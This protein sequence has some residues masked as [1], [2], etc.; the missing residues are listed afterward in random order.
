MTTTL[1][2]YI[3]KIADDALIMGQRLSE[4][5]GHGPYLEEDLA[6]TN[7]ALDQLGQANYLFQYAAKLDGKNK[8][9]DDVAFLR[10][11][12]QYLN[13]QLVELPNG[14]YAQ[15][16]VKIFLFAL[17]QQLLYTHL[18]QSKDPQ[19]AAVATKS[20]KEVNYHLQHA[21]TWITCF[22][23][24]TTESR[25]RLLKALRFVWSYTDDL[26]APID[27]EATLVQEGIA[28][29]S[30]VLRQEWNK[31]IMDAF[32]N[33]NIPM[34]TIAYMHKNSRK[35]THTEHMGFILADM[36]YMQRAYP[37]CKW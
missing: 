32:A 17:Y 4:W 12:K 31:K 6:I 29:F 27:N 19:L 26:F 30:E 24:G 3:L 37:G 18:Q 25:E 15:T 22:A 23:N 36:Q 21:T 1:Y 20:L 7:M 13:A 35:G 11:E 5:C 2:Q 16:I 8:T 10:F 9:E 33:A 14:D 28:P 34:P